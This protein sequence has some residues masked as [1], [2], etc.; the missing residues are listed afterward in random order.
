[1]VWGDEKGG[2]GLG[3]GIGGGGRVGRNGWCMDGGLD[4]RGSGHGDRVGDDVGGE[5]EFI[6]QDGGGERMC[7]G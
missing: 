6:G 3:I 1:M 5:V 2:R 4:E 7:W